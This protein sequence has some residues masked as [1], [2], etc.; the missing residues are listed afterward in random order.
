MKKTTI[1]FT[2]LLLSFA[3]AGYVSPVKYTSVKQTGMGGAGVAVVDTR[4]SILCNP[5]HVVDVSGHFTIP[6][7]NSSWTAGSETPGN[8]KKLSTTGDTDDIVDAYHDIIPSKVGLG[9]QTSGYGAFDL[10]NDAGSLGF[11]MY[12]Q[13]KF[14]ANVLNRLSPRLESIG[15]VDVAFPTITYGRKID[16]G[17]DA[18]FTNLKVGATIKRIARTSLYDLQNESDHV[19]IEVLNLLNEDNQTGLN[20]RVGTAYGLDLGLLTDIDTFMG[21]MKLGATVTNISTKFS[22]TQY[23]NVNSSDAKTE[24]PFAQGVPVLGTVGLAMKASPFMAVPFID[25]IFPDATYAADLDFISMDTSVF[26]RLHLGLEQQYFNK[27]L[28][29]RMGLNQ[30]YPTMGI[31]LNLMVYHLG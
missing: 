1:L 11:G 31:D 6:F 3:F 30:G 9:M 27:L 12:A 16:L 23:E 5:A 20:A 4:D 29:W 22:G 15:Y 26:K 25:A 28:S 17:K 19:N 13:G 21:P 10:G 2:T 18:Y 24:V 7:I 14:A 8:I